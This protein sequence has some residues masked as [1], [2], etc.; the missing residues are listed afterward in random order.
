MSVVRKPKAHV[1]PATFSIEL[2]GDS[3]IE[4]R[5]GEGPTGKLTGKIHRVSGYVKP[6]TVTLTGLPTEYVAPKIEVAGIA[7]EFELPIRFRYGAK[8]AELK[9]EDNRPSGELWDYLNE[10][11]ASES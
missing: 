4:A 6:V 8:V 3:T 5:A 9:T 7:T 2:T 11:E 1:R 10:L